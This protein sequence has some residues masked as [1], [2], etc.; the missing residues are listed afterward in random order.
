MKKQSCTT[1]KNAN[2]SYS[3]FPCKICNHNFS[4]WEE[5]IQEDIEIEKI[6]C[7]VIGCGK[8]STV[9]FCQEC[10]DK[11]FEAVHGDKI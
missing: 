7:G 1:C 4:Q 6:P 8:E 5:S 11:K 2:K 3:E 10:Y 9:H